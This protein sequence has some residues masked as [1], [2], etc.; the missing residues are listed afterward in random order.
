MIALATMP[1]HA[2]RKKSGPNIPNAQRNT[3]QVLVR[4]AP[5]VAARGR[6]LIERAA[7]EG[8]T[9]TWAHL[10]LN[11]IISLEA[12]DAEEAP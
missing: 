6:A 11:G 4:M 5:D 10:V 9:L 2:P 8:E 1:A 7:A 12:D 3:V